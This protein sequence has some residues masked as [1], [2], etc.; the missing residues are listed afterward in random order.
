MFFLSFVEKST[1]R[2]QDKK[3]YWGLARTTKTIQI[4]SKGTGKTFKSNN[5]LSGD[6]IVD[7]N[8]CQRRKK[9]TVSTGKTCQ[10]ELSFNK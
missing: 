9:V 10:T 3:V 4:L 8:C 6:E 5:F 7:F 1:K 2:S